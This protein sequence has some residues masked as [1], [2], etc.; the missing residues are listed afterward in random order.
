MMLQISCPNGHLRLALRMCKSSSPNRNT[1]Y[2]DTNED[3]SQ[4]ISSLMGRDKR[5][6]P[7]VTDTFWINTLVLSH[8]G[9][10]DWPSRTRK[11]QNRFNFIE[12]SGLFQQS[13]NWISKGGEV[14]KLVFPW[15]VE[16]R[17][18]RDKRTFLSVKAWLWS[19]LFSQTLAN[20]TTVLLTAIIWISWRNLVILSR[21]TYSSVCII[22]SLNRAISC[23]F[24]I[25]PS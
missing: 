1:Q 24:R 21:I 22:R 4:L 12:M 17:R 3:P 11:L 19:S 23:A 15:P 8:N 10:L 6:D 13:A 20:M 25:L 5:V 9:L 18:Y 7:S 16:W 14:V 2:F